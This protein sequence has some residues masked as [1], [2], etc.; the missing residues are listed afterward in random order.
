M[1]ASI[2]PQ[3][4][5]LPTRFDDEIDLVDLWLLFM[6]RRRVF[7]VTAL[8]VVLAALIYLATTPRLYEAR[9]VL[10]IGYL[11]AIGTGEDT[12][13]TNVSLE[14]PATFV[15][16]LSE[17]HRLSDDKR[18]DRPYPRIETVKSSK[19]Q[20]DIVTITAHAD[21]AAQAEGYLASVIKTIQR[22]HDQ[23][24]SEHIRNRQE[25]LEVLRNRSVS[26]KTLLS[27][28]SDSK[29][30]E[31]AV[32]AERIKATLELR[33]IERDITSLEFGISP[34]R[35]VP[36]RALRDAYA[37]DIPVKPRTTLVVA[38]AVAAGGLLGVLAVFF[39]EFVGR[40]RERAHAM[41]AVK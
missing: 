1:T 40:V 5:T 8:V 17:E 28:A 37:L 21:S 33:T 34:L 19:T 16:R 24:F 14:S 23:L 11:S 31:P 36:T 29:H 38:V 27:V 2:P 35:S 26:L 12:K 4:D 7:F 10:Q 41:Q 6:R 20:S 18:V 32:V 39:A 25:Q 15:E 30:V 9:A 22:D 13:I 3:V